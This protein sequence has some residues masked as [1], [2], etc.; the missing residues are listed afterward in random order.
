MNTKLLNWGSI[1]WQKNDS[2]QIGDMAIV[3]K[4][5]CP[6]LTSLCTNSITEGFEVRVE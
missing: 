5:D 3:A 2:N 6:K 4:W 1:E